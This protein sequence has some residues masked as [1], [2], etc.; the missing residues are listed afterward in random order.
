MNANSLTLY[1]SDYCPFCV[2]VLRFLDANN[3]E[4]PMKDTI[5]DPAVRQELIEL[6]GKGQVPAL[7]IGDEIMYESNDIINWVRANLLVKTTA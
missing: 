6:G 3:I 2:K 4:L 5:M 7:K 1:K